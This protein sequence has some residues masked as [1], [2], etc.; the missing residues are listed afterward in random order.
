MEYR[1]RDQTSSLIGF[2]CRLDW[3]MSLDEMDGWIESVIA[4]T[5][6]LR[7]G[8]RTTLKDAS[9]PLLYGKAR[10]KGERREGR[11]GKSKKGELGSLTILVER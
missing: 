5:G 8:L 7:R 10:G 2:V 4:S 11:A 3:S 6:S 1:E 9:T